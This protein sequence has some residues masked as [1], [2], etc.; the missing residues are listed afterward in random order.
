[1]EYKDFLVTDDG[2]TITAYMA[3]AMFKMAGM[4]IKPLKK[5][6]GWVRSNPPDRDFNKLSEIGLAEG[7]IRK[8]ETKWFLTKHGKETVK[9]LN[10]SVDAKTA[11]IMA[12][13]ATFSGK[14]LSEKLDG[15]YYHIDNETSSQFKED[16][17]IDFG[18]SDNPLREMAFRIAWENGHANGYNEV[19]NC[20]VDIAAIILEADRLIKEAG[21][22]K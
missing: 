11:E 20:F 2:T 18:V 6:F 16:L 3:V 15:N 17:F 19:M 10:D 12:I 5:V 13:K 8:G 22:K 7:H 14:S 21:N 9:W 4:D 1:M